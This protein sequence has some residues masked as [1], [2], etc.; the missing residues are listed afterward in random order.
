MPSPYA[1]APRRAA[2]AFIAVSVCLD[3]LAQSIS[4]PVLP[5][6]AQRLLG[7]DLVAA[8]RW[9]GV[10]EVAWAIPQF[11]AAPLLGML[12][13]RFGRRPVIVLSL[14]GIAGELTMNALA[15]NLTWLLAGRIL[16]GFTC[17]AQVAAMAYVADITPEAGRASAYGWLN[18]ALW[19]GVIVGPAAGGVLTAID[20]RTPFWF[21]AGVAL[22]CGLYGLA[23]LPESLAPEHR[24]PLRWTTANPWG[25]ID[26]LRRRPGLLALG[27]AQLLIW[28][29][30]QGTSNMM[31][32]Y[33]ASRYAWTPL[34]FGAFATALA[35]ANIAVQGGLAGRVVRTWGERRTALAGLGFQTLSTAA[36]GLASTGSLFW[37]ANLLGVI[38]SIY[39]P[40]L[41]SMMTAKVAPDEQGRLQG[42]I[43]SIS[44]LTGILAPIP[45]TQ[46]FAWTIAPGQPAALS[47]ATMLLGAGL[48]LIA[49]VV[50]FAFTRTADSAD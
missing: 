20:V 19:T 32:V 11:L 37:A 48:C 27:F 46:L 25:A 18:A 15:P 49:W 14:F 24:A 34:A 4:F 33:T 8:S 2:L 41:Q 44:S 45:F 47:G 17:G 7:G 3:Y 1:R 6:L 26:L 10:L 13:D 16:C 9:T 29:A 36:M 21:A 35:A 39:Q 42:A 28:L 38:G 23:V 30:F 50:V 5:R 43:G 40:A 31:V 12:S 22:V